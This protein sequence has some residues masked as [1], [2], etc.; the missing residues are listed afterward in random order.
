MQLAQL[1]C[2]ACAGVS[3]EIRYVDGCMLTGIHLAHSSS[4]HFAFYLYSVAQSLLVPSLKYLT[5]RPRSKAYFLNLQRQPGSSCKK[6]KAISMLDAIA[7][8]AVRFSRR[9][10]CDYIT[11]KVLLRLSV[12]SCTTIN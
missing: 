11:A 9:L 12:L 4:D 7:L 2:L 5:D 10:L 8:S 3:Y 6:S 1:H